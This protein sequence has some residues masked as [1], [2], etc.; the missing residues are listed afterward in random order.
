MDSING[1]AEQCQDWSEEFPTGFNG[2]IAHATAGDRH[3][4]ACPQCAGDPRI[5]DLPLH[6]LWQTAL[7][8]CDGTGAWAQVLSL[9]EQSRQTSPPHLCAPG[10]SRA[11]SRAISTAPNLSHAL[12]RAVRHRLR[13]ADPTSKSVVRINGI[14][15][16]ANGGVSRCEGRQ[17]TRGQHVG[18]RGERSA[19]VPTG[20]RGGAPCARR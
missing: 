3:A 9:G 13:V 10:T 1:Y 7:P 2:D 14:G 11:D 4:A 12:G 18:T 5:P 17:S 15:Q 20:T 19:L 8:V 6:A 16:P